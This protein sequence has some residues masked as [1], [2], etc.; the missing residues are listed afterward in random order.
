[1]FHWV[2]LEAKHKS[3]FEIRLDVNRRGNTFTDFTSQFFNKPS[4]GV[5]PLPISLS[6]DLYS[7]LTFI[8]IE[9]YI[10]SLDSCEP[11]ELD[12]AINPFASS[13]GIVTW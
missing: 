6:S 2:T 3:L 4:F 8:F 12:A 11:V 1:V 13:V 10:V 5:F 7:R 9:F